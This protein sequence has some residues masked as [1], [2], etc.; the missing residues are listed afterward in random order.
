M[1]PVQDLCV[2]NW[3]YDGERTQFPM[4]VVAIGTDYVYLD[5]E[6]NEGDL[7]ESHPDDVEGIPLTTELLEKIGFKLNPYEG[8]G[9]NV[10]TKRIKLEV[11]R[12]IF[13]GVCIDCGS[14]SITDLVQ[15]SKVLSKRSVHSTIAQYFLHELQNFVFITTKQELKINL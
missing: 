3:V 9:R 15:I 1:I 8:T 4:Q 12:E 5:F 14:I 13:I 7:W 6:G 11:A 2:G 10:Y